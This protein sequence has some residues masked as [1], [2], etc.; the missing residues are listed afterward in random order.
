MTTQPLPALYYLLWSENSLSCVNNC[1]IDVAWEK[2]S[3]VFIMEY[4]S[5]A[6]VPTSLE[7]W[8]LLL[9]C[10]FYFLHVVMHDYIYII[11]LKRRIKTNLWEISWLGYLLWIPLFITESLG[12]GMVGTDIPWASQWFSIGVGCRPRGTG[13]VGARCCVD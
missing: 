11:V 10:P 3:W 1:L 4:S 5:E 8:Q 13:T 12:T 7:A 2:P 9:Q 6:S